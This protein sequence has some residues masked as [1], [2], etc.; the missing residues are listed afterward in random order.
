MTTLAAAITTYNDEWI[1]KITMPILTRF[2]DEIF[3]QDD[4]S[5]DD[6]VALLQSFPNVKLSY[7]S[8]PQPRRNREEGRTRQELVDWVSSSTASHIIF[9]DADEVPCPRFPSWFFEHDGGSGITS[10]NWVHFWRDF[11]HVRIDSYRSPL[12]R[13]YHWGPSRGVRKFPLMRH[14]PRRDYFYDLSVQSGS[15]SR[16]PQAPQNPAFRGVCHQDTWSL[17]HF[18]YLRPD[19][20]SGALGRMRNKQNGLSSGLRNL[21]RLR[22]NFE[23]WYSQRKVQLSEWPDERKWPLV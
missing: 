22:R 19:R 10:A 13:E 21:E 5:S 16:Y 2:C 23:E 3:V 17:L 18:G 9:L 12:G 6:T 1:L 7:Y 14:V 20:S 4:G 11:D 15:C 8:N